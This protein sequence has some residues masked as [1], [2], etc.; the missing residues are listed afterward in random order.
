MK[1]GIKI[2]IASQYSIGDHALNTRSSLLVADELLKLGF[3]P[4]APLLSH[5]WHFLSPKNWDTWL[6]YDIQWM[7]VCDC[8][9]RVPGAS[10]GADREVDIALT[11]GIPVFYN[12]KDLQK[13]Y[14]PK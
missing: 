10:K 1:E 8:V 5:F 11:E 13:F 2:Y 12:I 7:L 14:K 6:E 9:L 3:V 4:F